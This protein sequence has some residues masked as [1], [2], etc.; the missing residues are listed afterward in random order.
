[1]HI[2]RLSLLIEI[3]SWK[4]NDFD[5]V[6]IDLMLSMNSRQSLALRTLFTF[7]SF[8]RFFKLKLLK[9]WN[10]FY[11]LHRNSILIWNYA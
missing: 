5:E 8:E 7:N 9:I 11:K 2:I 3:F 1:M 10:K 4:L 6:R